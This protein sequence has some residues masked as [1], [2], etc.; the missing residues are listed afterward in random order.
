MFW[1]FLH[2]YTSAVHLTRMYSFV[3]SKLLEVANNRQRDWG[4]YH[5][6]S[7]WISLW[8]KYVDKKPNDPF[9]NDP[10]VQ[11]KEPGWSVCMVT[12]V[13]RK[14]IKT[15]QRNIGPP[16]LFRESFHWGKTKKKK[17]RTTTNHYSASLIVCKW[18]GIRVSSLGRWGGLKYETKFFIVFKK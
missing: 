8:P 18:D 17:K 11:P 9:Y 4:L 3:D 6:D 12:N 13:Q 2:N 14:E 15:Q 10:E 16:I 5:F 1:W 7:D